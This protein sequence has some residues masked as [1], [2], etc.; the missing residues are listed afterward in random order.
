MDRVSESAKRPAKDVLLVPFVR[1]HE[2]SLTSGRH[3]E[4]WL[5]MLSVL[6][7][8]PILHLLS[9]SFLHLLLPLAPTACTTRSTVIWASSTGESAETLPD[10]AIR[11]EREPTGVYRDGDLLANVSVG[12]F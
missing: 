5:S 6:S 10:A 2:S 1:E 7:T 8:L 12:Y 11:C 4:A 9:A 3:L